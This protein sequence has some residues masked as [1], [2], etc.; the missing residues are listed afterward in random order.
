MNELIEKKKKI[1][2]RLDNYFGVG[3][4][5]EKFGSKGFKDLV[6]ELESINKKLKKLELKNIKIDDLSFEQIEDRIKFLLTLSDDEIID[7]LFHVIDNESDSP[8]IT[9]CPNVV[10]SEKVF[11]LMSDERL[12][13]FRKKLRELS[14]DE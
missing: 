13:K 10:E 4:E 2:D 7:Y 1:Q 12:E 6:K 5:N 8:N 9:P 3:G 11:L 14:D